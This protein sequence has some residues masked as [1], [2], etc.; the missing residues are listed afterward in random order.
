MEEEGIKKKKRRSSFAPGRR[1]LIPKVVSESES[2]EESGDSLTED[3]M[4]TGL[5]HELI[6]EHKQEQSD[7]NNYIRKEKK[8]TD[9]FLNTADLVLN[10]SVTEEPDHLSPKYRDALAKS[11][12]VVECEREAAKLLRGRMLAAE[13][14][15]EKIVQSA[16]TKA[17]RWKRRAE[18]AMEKKR[19]SRGGDETLRGDVETLLMSDDSGIGADSTNNNNAVNHKA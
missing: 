3:K 14:K 9:D 6:A 19:E 5:I 1:S 10:F 4:L 15:M 18:D 17:A 2:D 11:S 8:E 12:Q 7:W 16:E 13:V